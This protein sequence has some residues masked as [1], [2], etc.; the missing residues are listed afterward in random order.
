MLNGVNIVLL[1]SVLIIV[2]QKVRFERF[3]SLTCFRRF[4]NF[5]FSHIM[6]VESYVHKL[7]LAVDEALAA[8]SRAIICKVF[9]CFGSLERK[10][11]LFV[12]NISI[13]AEESFNLL[14]DALLA[15]FFQNKIFISFI[16]RLNCVR[17]C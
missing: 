3:V 8:R 6:L 13:C 9:K 1:Y 5:F 17:N 10:T 7:K 14:N 2:I 15:L 12:V 11:T 4:Q 16:L